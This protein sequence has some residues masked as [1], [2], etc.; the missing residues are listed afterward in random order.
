MG[1]NLTTQF[2]KKRGQH[3]KERTTPK[4]EEESFF[5]AFSWN[6]IAPPL[7]IKYVAL[8]KKLQNP[9]SRFFYKKPT[10]ILFPSND[11]QIIHARSTDDLISDQPNPQYTRM[12]PHKT[13]GAQA[14][15]RKDI[16]RRALGI[17]HIFHETQAH[18]W[19]WR[20]LS[21]YLWHVC[22]WIDML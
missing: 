15:N 5:F 8:A 2:I 6:S 4:R 9:I 18:Q 16:M 1:L 10:N 21:C 14:F 20:H 3:Q 12:I 11:V 22:Y 19:E 17:C 13:T 7:R